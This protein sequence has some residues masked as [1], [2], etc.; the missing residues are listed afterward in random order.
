[1]SYTR[2][3][4]H[5]VFRTKCSMNVISESHEK[6]LYAYIYGFIKNKGAVLYRIGG[7]PNHI[8]LLVDIPPSLSVS[9]FM[10]EL[11][12]S[13]SRWLKSNQDFSQFQGWAEGYAAFTYSLNEKETIINYIMN[14]KEHH[15][16]E[17]FEDEYRHFIE[18]SGIKIDEKYFLKD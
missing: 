18:E 13:S 14:Q 16:V 2:F 5:I 9:S 10:Q 11:K 17:T 8:H 6:D 4:Y 12:T 15:R 7:M 1:M 3:L